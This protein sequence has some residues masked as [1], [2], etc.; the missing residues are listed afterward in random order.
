MRVMAAAEPRTESCVL[1]G[2]RAK[3]T[4]RMGVKTAIQDGLLSMGS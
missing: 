3:L 2:A 1:T 4:G